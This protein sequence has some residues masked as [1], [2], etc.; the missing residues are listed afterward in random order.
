MKKK[1]V[2]PFFLILCLVAGTIWQSVMTQVEK[3]KYYTIGDCHPIKGRTAWCAPVFAGR[4]GDF[5]CYENEVYCSRLHSGG[6]AAFLLCIHGNDK[7]ES[8]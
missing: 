7:G 5:V 4:N 2:F 8:V 3:S 1:F 6:S